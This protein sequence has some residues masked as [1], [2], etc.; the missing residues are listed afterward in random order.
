MNIT[1]LKITINTGDVNPS[2]DQMVQQSKNG[3]SVFKLIIIYNFL[4]MLII[5]QYFSHTL[6]TR[7][8]SEHFNF[9]IFT[10]PSSKHNYYLHC[11]HKTWKKMRNCPRVVV[12]LNF[13]GKRFVPSALPWGYVLMSRGISGCHTCERG[14]T[15][16]IWWV[17]AM[18]AAI[19]LTISTTGLPSQQIIICLKISIMSRMR[20]STLEAFLLTSIIYN[21]E[22]PRITW[23][24]KVTW[25]IN[26]A[27]A[28]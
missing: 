11:L 5:I 2:H 22:G 8:C 14:S 7:Q 25:C 9:L 20:N 21:L 1:I 12:I 3:H 27:A 4:P 24:L 15:T 26:L 23:C 28:N 18:D 17:E 6:H 13:E 19:H 10:T 16:G